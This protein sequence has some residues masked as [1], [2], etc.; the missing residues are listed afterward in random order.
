MKNINELY[1]SF[2]DFKGYFLN[3]ASF[4]ANQSAD[5]NALLY[6]IDSHLVD[7]LHTLKDNTK[8]EKEKSESA[9]TNVSGM[10]NKINDLFEN[11]LHGVVNAFDS[12][13]E[14]NA[15]F[16]Y[17]KS[18][19]FTVFIKDLMNSL[20]LDGKY[21]DIS[22]LSD[23]Y[24]S[25]SRGIKM[26]ADSIGPI[27]KGLFLFNIMNKLGGSRHFIKFLDDLYN[28]EFVQSSDTKEIQELGIN[29]GILSKSM[30]SFSKNMAIAT[31]LLL[32]ASPMILLSYPLIKIL[33]SSL[34]SIK[35]HYDDIKIGSEGLKE[36]GK[37]VL[38]LSASMGI[39]ALMP[40]PDP[41][42]VLMLVGT[43]GA[44]TL[45]MYGIRKM[46]GE[47]SHNIKD[48]SIGLVLMSGAMAAFALTIPLFDNVSYDN[49][50]KAGATITFL[51]ILTNFLGKS[52]AKVLFAPVAMGLLVGAT[53]LMAKTAQ[54]FR[55]V[56][57]EDLLK[58]GLTLAGFTLVIKLLSNQYAIIGGLV[59]GGVALAISYS[60]KLIS[61]SVSNITN[62]LA[63]F[64]EV[65]WTKHDSSN[66]ESAMG[67]LISGIMGGM[68]GGGVLQ[69]LSN[70]VAGP[71]AML[72]M[73]G[74][75]AFSGMIID[76]IKHFKESG[77]T[78]EDSENAAM[79]IAT[80]PKILIAE[81]SGGNIFNALGNLVSS[82]STS[83]SSASLSAISLPV[84]KAIEFIKNSGLTKEESE[85]AAMVIAAYPKALI[86]ETSGGNVF[87]ALGNMVKGVSTSIS[88]GS[89]AVISDPVIRAIST[90]KKSKLTKED[91]ADAANIVIA[92]VDKI[93]EKF[94][95]GG[96]LHSIG[97][98]V[99]S[100]AHSIATDGIGEMS[101]N[102]I[103]VIKSVNESKVTKSNAITAASV[104]ISFIDTVKKTF[105]DIG[106]T[107]GVFTDSDFENG[108]EAIGSMGDMATNI[109]NAVQSINNSGVTK[110]NAED[111]S[112]I[113]NSF[114]SGIK[115]VFADIGSTE[116][117]FTDS[118]FE[119]GTEAL[120]GVGEIL[121]DL[122]TNIYNISNLKF[123]NNKEN[124]EE[125]IELSTNDMVNASKNVAKML[126]TIS[127]SVT[128]IGGLDKW[129]TSGDF[130]KGKAAISGIGG[131]LTQI[132]A[133]VNFIINEVDITDGTKLDSFK[134][135]LTEY[136]KSVS[137]VNNS[138]NTVFSGNFDANI[139]KYN[140]FF[141]SW[142]E[143]SEKKNDIE[144]VS[145][146]IVSI[147]SSA[148]D[149]LTTI[150]NVTIDNIDAV[151]KLFNSIKD[152]NESNENIFSSLIN[153]ANSIVTKSNDEKITVDKKGEDNVL[154]QQMVELLRSL[155]MMQSQLRMSLDDIVTTL[156]G[157]LLV[158]V[159][160]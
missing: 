112:T 147:N 50:L 8:S 80:Y 32:I 67:A 18:V 49:L 27:S 87:T 3:S 43:V 82:V 102:I 28:S 111:A 29:L 130:N 40:T 100:K 135:F 160:E 24:I 116:G 93:D 72:I 20:T 37:G 7:I 115:T 85:D 86:K 57:Y 150:S 65:G 55:N 14:K 42:N 151:T 5:N 31:P 133:S 70:I 90:V 61:S 21:E 139:K 64:K 73:G 9:G 94:N 99:K 13:F 66:L 106:S 45:M 137:A 74:I 68:T 148:T 56:E 16:D 71:S 52:G 109:I 104:I 142:A 125:S 156:R 158:E 119:N 97:N 141:H 121:Y 152:A 131:L 79:V 127:S 1:N 33:T 17:S 105:T 2:E 58:M 69:T 51:T 126:D 54:E 25:S 110:K 35:G 89:F 92:Y 153:K 12:F 15:K 159:D 48:A 91:S 113:I 34:S 143:L 132:G 6:N 117:W 78:K 53:Y 11:E 47:K 59:V 81:T 129:Y 134:T 123:G 140:Q 107:E 38:L 39:L 62:A 46:G 98:M 10:Y 77:L 75:G 118:D 103:S 145:K 155:V 146:S 122:A 36:M 154:D 144:L 22:Q 136:T 4:F 44:L 138:V 63:T 101:T 83:I 60:I 84:I 114:V 128:K 96:V 95:K 149:L 23:L 124:G 19:K 157:K 26:L 41:V 108:I 88:A 120:D 30:L 76:T